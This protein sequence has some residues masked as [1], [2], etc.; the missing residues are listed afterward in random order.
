MEAPTF[1][2]VITTQGDRSLTGVV[3]R[4]DRKP[5]GNLAVQL[6]TTAGETTWTTWREKV[7]V[8]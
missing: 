4:V 7:D 1:G 2:Q 8:K 5:N 6:I 3:I